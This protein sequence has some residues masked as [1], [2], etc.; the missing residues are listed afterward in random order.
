MRSVYARVLT[1]GLLVL[2]A[3]PAFAQPPGGRGMFQPN[4]AMLLRDPKVKEELKLTDDQK[5]A[6]EK[7]DEKYKSKFED[8][9]GDREKM[10]ELFKS[11]SADVDKVVADSLKP[12]QRKRLNQLLVQRSGI[13]AFSKDDVKTALKLTDTQEKDIK[14][15]QDEL[16]KDR[17]DLFKDV[18]EDREKRAEAGKKVQAMQKEAMDKIVEGFTDDQKKEWK[19]LTGAKF[20]FAPFGG[21]RPPPADAKPNA[22]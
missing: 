12:D 10:T 7:I 17:E 13:N 14:T 20:E 6:F 19:E 15:T 11:A 22:K 9:Q 5:A 2:L 8:A 1:A 4:A 21:F 16:R 18:G 3:S